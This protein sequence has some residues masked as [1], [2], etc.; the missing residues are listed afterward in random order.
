MEDAIQV[1]LGQDDA[2]IL[3][4][5]STGENLREWTYS[6]RSEDEFIDRFKL[7][8]TGLPLFPIEL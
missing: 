4:L 6:T 2:A 3:A 5:V 8:L 7:A 1:I